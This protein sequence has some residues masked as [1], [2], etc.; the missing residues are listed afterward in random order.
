MKIFLSI[1]K[2]NLLSIMIY[3][4]QG[5]AMWPGVKS[6]TNEGCAGAGARRELPVS[7][8]PRWSQTLCK[9]PGVKRQLFSPLMFFHCCVNVVFCCAW[10]VWFVWQVCSFRHT[11]QKLH[12]IPYGS[13]FPV[14]CSF[15]L[16]ASTSINI[17]PT[18]RAYCGQDCEVGGS[19]F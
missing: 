6:E 16:K 1:N 18:L 4:G 8:L 19:T 17:F 13:N 2:K 9:K 7:V 3:S 12:G 10:K 14:G 15:K 5:I 11:S